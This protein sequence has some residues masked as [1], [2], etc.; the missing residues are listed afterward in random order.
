MCGL[1]AV[2]DSF[3]ALHAYVTEQGPIEKRSSGSWVSYNIYGDNPYLCEAEQQWTSDYQNTILDLVSRNG[4]QQVQDCQQPECYS[5]L[6]KLCLSVGD[7]TTP[8]VES[9]VVG[10]VYLN[11]YGGIDAQCQLG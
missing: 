1:D 3:S 8:G 10:E 9:E 11:S 6:Q 5:I 4:A 2:Y 7:S